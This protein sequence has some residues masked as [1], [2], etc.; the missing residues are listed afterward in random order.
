M[1]WNTVLTTRISA[2]YGKNKYLRI[3]DREKTQRVLLFWQID[4]LS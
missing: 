4:I 2:A 3:D 1:I